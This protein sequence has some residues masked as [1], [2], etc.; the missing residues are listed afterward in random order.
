MDN[1]VGCHSVKE[2]QGNPIYGL[3]KAV[4]DALAAAFKTR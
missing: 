1:A 3:K 4:N 2:G